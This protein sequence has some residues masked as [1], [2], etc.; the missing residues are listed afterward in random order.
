MDLLTVKVIVLALS[1][2]IRL[3]FGLFPLI[4]M[5]TLT[6]RF[7]SVKDSKKIKYVISMLMFFGDIFLTLRQN[8]IFS[9]NWA[10]WVIYSPAEE[11]LNNS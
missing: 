1:G 7:A 11:L 2:V 5:K 9:D 8:N 3:L 6:R 10:N 4:L